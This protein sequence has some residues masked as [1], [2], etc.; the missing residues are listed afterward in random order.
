MEDLT[1]YG[2]KVFCRA[3]SPESSGSWAA[4]QA[5]GYQS[6]ATEGAIAASL[7]A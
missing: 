7:L 5:Q 6:E 4:E 1:V 3:A 2:G